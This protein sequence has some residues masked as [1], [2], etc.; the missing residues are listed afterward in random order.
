M[1]EINPYNPVENKVDM[2]Y[3]EDDNLE[4]EVE[5]VALKTKGL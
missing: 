5:E 1:Y 4:Y 3:K 2:R